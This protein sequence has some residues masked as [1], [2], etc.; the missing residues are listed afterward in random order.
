MNPEP[1]NEYNDSIATIIARELKEYAKANPQRAREIVFARA[2]I[3]EHPC[4]VEIEYTDDYP[5]SESYRGEYTET[6]VPDC[7]LTTYEF[8]ARVCMPE[9]H[10]E[11]FAYVE[12]TITEFYEYD[13]DEDGPTVSVSDYDIEIDE[14]RVWH[15]YAED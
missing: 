6:G 15:C 13:R 14:I 3:L 12:G 7:D 10:Y 9:G 4:N 11:I 8:T 5:E 2:E 1:M